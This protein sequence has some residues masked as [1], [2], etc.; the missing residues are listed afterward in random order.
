MNVH[1]RGACV[2]CVVLC[3][4]YDPADPV[5]LNQK[6]LEYAIRK[7]RREAG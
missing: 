5:I 7:L 4:T 3:V 1:A 6:K 2:V